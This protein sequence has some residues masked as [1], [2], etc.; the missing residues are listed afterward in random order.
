MTKKTE[1]IMNNRISGVSSG[2]KNSARLLV[3]LGAVLLGLGLF[4]DQA[5][6]S[7]TKQQP[8]ITSTRATFAIPT[9]SPSTVT[10]E[11][12]LWEFQTKG[13][14]FVGEDSGSSG[15]LFVK[16]PSTSTCYFQLDVT[17]NGKFYSG[18]R[19][20]IPFCGGNSVSGT[21]STT[22]APT[23]TTSRTTPT[24]SKT[25]PTTSKPKTSG[26]GGTTPST[27]SPSSKSGGGASP[28]TGSST[29]VAPSALAF[30]GTGVMT[31]IVALIGLLLL[32][33]GASLLL[34][35]RR[36]PTA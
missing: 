5:G 1:A 26:G 16:V 11:L 12:S 10:W 36:Y 22:V 29:T 35:A 18:F 30:T 28:T 13:Q 31:W 19:K 15:N 24:T 33:A 17:K 32:A 21:T 20:V 2:I 7:S 8:R 14:K 25:T 34:Y 3:V 23:T 4:A 6:A 27:A 9:N